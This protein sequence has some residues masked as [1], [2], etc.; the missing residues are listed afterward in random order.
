MFQIRCSVVTKMIKM[1]DFKVF[2]YLFHV[3]FD[4]K[5]KA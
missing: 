2:L 3:S 5:I 1:A 4:L